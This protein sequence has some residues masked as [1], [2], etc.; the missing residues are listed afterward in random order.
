M[1]KQCLLSSIKKENNRYKQ[2]IFIGFLF[3]C[4]VKWKIHMY[5]S[6]IQKLHFTKSGLSP[7]DGSDICFCLNMSRCCLI[8]SLHF[9][10]VDS[11][12]MHVE[13]TH[14]SLKHALSSWLRIKLLVFCRSTLNQWWSR[15][16]NRGSVVHFSMGEHEKKIMA[17]EAMVTKVLAEKSDSHRVF[18]KHWARRT[19][20]WFMLQSLEVCE[21]P[22]EK[23]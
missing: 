22:S 2:I 5:F 9:T 4:K 15:K 23:V 12:N 8:P 19:D 17:W 21:N 13:W 16:E 20:F 10:C 3:S 6:P 14:L 1:I 11:A 7:Q 18:F